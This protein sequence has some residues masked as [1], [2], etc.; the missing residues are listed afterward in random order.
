MKSGTNYKMTPFN[1]FL[2]FCNMNFIYIKIISCNE[3]TEMVKISMKKQN[4]LFI[5]FVM[6][7]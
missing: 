6:K 2:K 4:T 3:A 1:F 7:F 5:E